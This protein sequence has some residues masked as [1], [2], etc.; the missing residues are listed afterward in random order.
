LLSYR[1]ALETAEPTEAFPQWAPAL[2][3]R[4]VHEPLVDVHLARLVAAASERIVVVAERIGKEL[5]AL[6]PLVDGLFVVLEAREHGKYR[7]GWVEGL[8]HRVALFAHELVRSE[9]RRVGKGW[10]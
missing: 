2:L 8:A 4:R 3:G 5:R 1:G 10:G 9:E 6:E 7:Q